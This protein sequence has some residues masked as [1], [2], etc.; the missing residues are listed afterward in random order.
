MLLNSAMETVLACLDAS[1]APGL[2]GISLQFVKY[3]EEVL[4]LPP[5][6]LVNLSMKQS[7]F[8]DQCNIPNVS[9]I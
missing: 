2:D 5:Y 9:P 6:N 3:G 4:A 8:L 1:K 7:S